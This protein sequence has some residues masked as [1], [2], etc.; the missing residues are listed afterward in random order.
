[1]PRE[2]SPALK[3]KRYGIRSDASCY[4]VRTN[5]VH[6]RVR[7]TYDLGPTYVSLQSV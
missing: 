3:V 1:M 6:R 4:F 2:V 5:S 7:A